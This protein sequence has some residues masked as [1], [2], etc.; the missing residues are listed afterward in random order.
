MRWLDSGTAAGWLGTLR[1]E[2]EEDPQWAEM[3]APYEEQFPGL[4]ARP[5]SGTDRDRVSLGPGSA[6]PGPDRP[7]P[8][9]P[10][11]RCAGPG[12]INGTVNRYATPEG[13]SPVVGGPVRRGARGSRL[14]SHPAA[15]AEATTDSAGRPG[16]GRRAVADV[17]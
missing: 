4:G 10:A 11:C 14:R 5:G 12:G 13:R 9:V 8:R 1:D 3:I 16:R 7:S 6:R 2:L 15:G 17:R